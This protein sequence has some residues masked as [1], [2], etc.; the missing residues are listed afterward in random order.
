LPPCEAQERLAKLLILVDHLVE[1]ILRIKSTISTLLHSTIDS[2]INSM[3]TY[4]TK[5]IP[6]ACTL[7]TVGIVVTPAKY[8]TKNGVPVLRSLNVWP[9]HFDLND[10]KTIT[11]AGNE[12]HL[13]S[14]LQVNDIVMVRTGDAGRPGNAAIVTPDMAGWNCV[15]VILAR[16]KPTIRPHFLIMLLNSKYYSNAITAISPGTKQKHLGISNLGRISIPVPPIGI[17]DSIIKSITS[18]QTSSDAI[19]AL[20]TSLLQIR[21]SLINGISD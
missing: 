8:Y 21:T 7:L 9:G 11:N 6:D 3:A 4:K 18:L 16:P 15:D 5:T 13:K 1:S 19:S 17:Q 20:Y 12:I 10:L 14:S 2:I